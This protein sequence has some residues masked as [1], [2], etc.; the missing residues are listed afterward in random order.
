M[1]NT[2]IFSWGCRFW[3][4]ELPWVEDRAERTLLLCSLQ[5]Q[6]VQSK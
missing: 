3:V 6:Q 4:S 2:E 1:H 5:F